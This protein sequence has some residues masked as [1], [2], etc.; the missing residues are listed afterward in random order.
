[1]AQYYCCTPPERLNILDMRCDECSLR[2]SVSPDHMRC[3]R[4]HGRPLRLPARLIWLLLCACAALP[5]SG[6]VCNAACQNQQ[7]AAVASFYSRLQAAQR[8]SASAAMQSPAHCSW[9]GNY[10]LDLS[11]GFPSS[12]P[13]ECLQP[14]GISAILLPSSQLTGSLSDQIWTSLATS[15]EYLD[16][17][18][19]DLSWSR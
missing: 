3:I 19:E 8:P 6:S 18:G 16:L 11:Q 4:R 12:T 15:M 7:L 2:S 9:Q 1:M 14:Y 17:T 13:V 10:T 5:A